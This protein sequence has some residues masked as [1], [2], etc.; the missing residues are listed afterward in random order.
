MKRPLLG[1]V[2]ILAAAGGIAQTPPQARPAPAA[3]P[4]P[5]VTDAPMTFFVTS[6][7][8]TQTGNLG[9]LEGADRICQNLA[10][11]V[12]AGNRIWRAYLSTQAT[13]ANGRFIG[14]IAVNAR[15][16][17]GK[18]PWHNAKGELIAADVADLHGDIQRDRNNIR[19]NTALNEKGELNPGFG[20]KDNAH[21]ILTGSDSGGRAFPFPV[22]VD[23]TCNNWTSDGEDHKAMVGHADRLGGANSSWNSVH[24]TKDCSRE[25]LVAYGGAGNLY[26]FAVN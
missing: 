18:G 26:C 20:Q 6:R 12:G 24:P 8:P 14:T 17:I 21:D 9:G 16:R 7:T 19:A 11:S 25:G 5:R 1:L 10:Q 2:A 23:M 3:S 13:P 22:G 15:D 4:G